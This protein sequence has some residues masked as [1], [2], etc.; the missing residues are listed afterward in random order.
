MLHI[1]PTNCH[2]PVAKQE[3]T[4][5]FISYRKIMKSFLGGKSQENGQIGRKK[6]QTERFREEIGGKWNQMAA[7][8]FQTVGRH[9]ASLASFQGSLV[10]ELLHSTQYNERK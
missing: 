3:T 6:D 8:R 5:E 10:Y 7:L 1:L 2:L 4:K 9:Q